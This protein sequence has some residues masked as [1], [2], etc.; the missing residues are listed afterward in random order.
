[1][2][3]NNGLV[4]AREG[5]P[6]RLRPLPRAE[7]EGSRPSLGRRLA[8]GR[9]PIVWSLALLFAFKSLVGFAIAAFPLSAEQPGHIAFVGGVF[10]VL[11]ACAVWLLGRGS[12]RVASS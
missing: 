4:P 10:A 12:P 1:M 9:P 11:A 2:L 7:P 3:P 5:R 8:G 6:A